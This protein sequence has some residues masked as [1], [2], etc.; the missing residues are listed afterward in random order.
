MIEAKTEISLLQNKVKLFHLENANLRNDLQKMENECDMLKE[1]N[2]SLKQDMRIIDKKNGKLQE[3]LNALLLE[4]ELLKCNHTEKLQTC[5]IGVQ[6]DKKEGPAANIMTFCDELI[7]IPRLIS[8]FEDLECDE[9]SS[10]YGLQ[11]SSPSELR[12][13]HSLADDNC[14]N[15][16]QS[17]NLNSSF[18]STRSEKLLDTGQLSSKCCTEYTASVQDDDT[19]ESCL[20]GF[21][22][23]QEEGECNYNNTKKRKRVRKTFMKRCS[24]EIYNRVLKNVLKYINSSKKKV[25]LQNCRNN[26]FT[27]RK[28]IRKK[29]YVRLKTKNSIKD[30]IKSLKHDNLNEFANRDNYC[31]DAPPD[32]V[33]S[34]CF[35]HISTESECSEILSC[36]LSGSISELN[37][38]SIRDCDRKKRKLELFGSDSESDTE[39]SNF[40]DSNLTCDSS[41]TPSVQI[42]RNVL[43]SNNKKLQKCKKT[44]N[45]KFNNAATTSICN[46]VYPHSNSVEADHNDQHLLHKPELL[47]SIQSANFVTEDGIN[48]SESNFPTLSLSPVKTV[49][50]ADGERKVFKRPNC[51]KSFLE[52]PRSPEPEQKHEI[53]THKPVIIPLN[54]PKPLTPAITNK[55][56]EKLLTYPDEPQI[57]EEVSNKLS[58]QEPAWISR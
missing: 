44:E 42:H 19:G 35:P 47:S 28:T 18:I 52:T 7:C 23:A 24:D 25:L 27:R 31:Y 51:R 55:L 8:P 38:Q 15:M 53:V 10:P 41:F 50:E 33:D 26:K 49:S 14:G 57:L 32:S 5:D 48:V 39:S 22:S 34:G 2:V 43:M 56:F 17:Q 45:S 21:A 1:K 46:N 13:I 54:K 3:K 12:D 16:I 29:R 30:K 4:M 40:S 36:K 11:C 37:D 58:N 9:S 20:L 6:T